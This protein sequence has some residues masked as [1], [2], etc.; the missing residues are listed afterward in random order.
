MTLKQ[1]SDAD[2]DVRVPER[3]LNFTCFSQTLSF[4][5]V[6]LARRLLYKT[7]QLSMIFI[8]LITVIMH[9]IIL[10]LAFCIY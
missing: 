9:V 5:T 10:L 7:V 6:N 4:E 8:L 2:A 3:I 1:E